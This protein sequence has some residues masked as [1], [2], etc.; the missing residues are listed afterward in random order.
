M[1]GTDH[2]IPALETVQLWLWL[3]TSRL[4]NFGTY[5]GFRRSGRARNLGGPHA[6]AERLGAHIDPDAARPEP[7]DLV[8]RHARAA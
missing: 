6:L 3:W 8:Y 1:T 5:A 4:A 7:D 2:Y